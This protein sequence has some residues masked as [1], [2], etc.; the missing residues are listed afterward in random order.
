MMRRLLSALLLA[1][2]T[3]ASADVCDDLWF[4]R[5]QIMDRAGYCFRTPLGQSVF[6]NSGCIGEQVSLNA[7]ARRQVEDIR[8]RESALGCVV[9][10]KRRNLD[11]PDIAIRWNLRDLPVADEYESGCIGWLEPVT[12]LHSGRD[13]A[14][15]IVGWIEPGDNVLYGHWTADNDPWLFVT[16]WSPDSPR[17]K[18]AGWLGLST[19]E[20]SCRNWA[21]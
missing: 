4:T 5:N 3:P 17:F 2:S 7:Q 21:G 6:D 19:N 1:A 15:A 10:T 12:S 18:S 20:K 9:D 13:S 8:A 14:S 16:V 11:L